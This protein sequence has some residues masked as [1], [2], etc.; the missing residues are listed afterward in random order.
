[1]FRNIIKRIVYRLRGECTTEELIEKG[2]IVGRS[3]SRQN[4]VFLDYGHCWLIEIGDNVTLAPRV[5]IL[6]HDASTKR[7]LGYTKIGKVTIGNN[8]F[9]GTAAVI[10]PNVTIGNNVIVGANSTV[11]SNIPDNT[12]V[13]GSPA[14]VISDMD[15][16][17]MRMKSL[18][19]KGDNPVYEEEYTERGGIDISKKEQMKRE[20]KESKIGFVK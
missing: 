13:A 1:M 4:N 9:I 15:T 7:V 2:M 6:C 3:F 14:V 5:C 16:Y 18:I 20:L 19:E 17:L 11:C 12:V 8:V 10:L